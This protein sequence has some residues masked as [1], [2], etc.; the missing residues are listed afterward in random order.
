MERPSNL[1]LYLINLGWLYDTSGN[2]DLSF[3]VAGF[4]IILCGVLL[5]ILPAMKWTKHWREAKTEVF[6]AASLKRNGIPQ[7]SS[8]ICEEDGDLKVTSLLTA[9]SGDRNPV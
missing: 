9:C 2:Y 4:F 5:I 8:M 1:P 3:Y 6:S 7:Q